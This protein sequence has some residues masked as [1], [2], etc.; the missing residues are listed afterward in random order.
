M[1]MKYYFTIL[2]CFL[3][4]VGCNEL[5]MDDGRE[6]LASPIMLTK[7]QQEVA[8]S[9]VGFAFNLLRELSQE[10]SGENLFISPIGV[11]AVSCMMANGAGD[12][13]RD[14]ILE[15]IGL[16]GFTIDQM[17]DYYATMLTALKKADL[18]VSFL[19]ANSLWA[20]KDLK[21]YRSYQ[22]QMD[23]V[24]GADMFSVDFAATGA[25]KKINLWCSDQT[26]GRIPKMFE[27]IPEETRLMLINALYFKGAWTCAFQESATREDDFITL[28]GAKERIPFM[29]M[30]ALMSGYLD[31]E[32]SVVKL[33][34]GN[35]TFYLEAIMPTGSFA[36][37]LQGLTVE[38]LT[39][40]DMPNCEAIALKFPRFKEEC[41]TGE[42][43]IPV[44]NRL[45]MNL[46][47]TEDADFSKMA[48]KKLV[49]DEMRQKTYLSIDEKGTEAAAV[50]V[51]RFRKAAAMTDP[52]VV[53]MSFDRPFVY[54][55]REQ[56]T[57][58]ILFI[59]TKVK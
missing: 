16:K 10:R 58:A 40:W 35:E 37:F 14:E 38:K 31:E 19:S 15:A 1:R 55:I 6:E 11:S 56:S 9:S 24:Y 36:S 21:L 49:V 4:M 12:A 33:P 2:C 39:N 53:E 43:L 42:A 47:F 3:L 23:K 57:G 18:S 50:T 17:N 26:Q 25:L 30:T 46:A 20:S 13:T 34:Y 32:V 27:Q 8:D 52:V 44:M 5:A 7:S 29:N 51:A 48:E 22:K 59:G 41:D 28:S 54:L 45:G